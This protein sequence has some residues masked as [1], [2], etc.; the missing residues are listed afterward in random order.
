MPTMPSLVWMRTIGVSCV[1]N[2]WIASVRTVFGTRSTCRIS[3]RSILAMF[4]F[5]LAQIMAATSAAVGIEG[6]APIRCTQ[7]DAAALA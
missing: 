7:I 3:T 2:D 6:A 5:L 1:A 4:S